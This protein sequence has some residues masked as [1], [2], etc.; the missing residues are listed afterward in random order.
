MSFISIQLNIPNRIGI[1]QY[2]SNL[3]NKHIKL[4][5]N[6]Q[7]E[8]EFTYHSL[9]LIEVELDISLGGRDHAE[10]GLYL[11]LLGIGIHLSIQDSRHWNHEFDRWET[12]DEAK[13]WSDKKISK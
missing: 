10:I 5:K 9:T 12:E 2:F 6:K 3:W 4:S 1:P 7:F 11:S 13:F 8:I